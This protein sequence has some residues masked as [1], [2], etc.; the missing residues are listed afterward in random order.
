MTKSDKPT[1][2]MPAPYVDPA[3]AAKNPA[4]ARYAQGVAQRR[5]PTKYHEPRGG[6]S[7]PPI[8]LLSAPHVDGMPMADQARVQRQGV[9]QPPPGIFGG[10]AT[11]PPP[12]PPMARQG[13]LPTDLLPEI[14]RHDPAFVEGHGSQFATNQPAL[15]M[16]YGV[17]R[18]GHPIPAQQ[19]STGRPGLSQKTVAGLEA[20][21]Q[22]NEQRQKA[23]SGDTAAERAAEEGLGGA[24]ARAAN[25]PGDDDVKTVSKEEAERALRSMDDFDFNNFREMMMKDLLNNDEQ[26]KIIE[27]RVPPLSLD[28]LIMQGRVTQ[29]IPVIPGQYEPE[30]QSVT[31]SEDLALKRLLMAESKSVEAPDRYLLDKYSLMVIALGLV[32][33]N[34]RPFPSHLDAQ[35]VWDDKAFWTKFNRV[36]NLPFHLLASLGVHYFWFDIRVRKLFVAERLKNG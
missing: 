30:L 17:I 13:L 19:L 31:G 9:S 15:A 23:E 27:E 28:A 7:A 12:A 16:K 24:A 26:R 14:A 18:N 2:G 3:I 11:E 34:K 35:G 6:G 10:A 33:I 25:A 29:V 5:D 20:L 36:L 32:S 21:K 1:T 22:F 4:A 8:P